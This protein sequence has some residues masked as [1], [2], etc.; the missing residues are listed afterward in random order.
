MTMRVSICG[1]LFCLPL[2]AA[3]GDIGA[4]EM[5]KSHPFTVNA[6][7]VKGCVLGSGASD[8]DTFGNLNFGQISSLDSDIRIVSRI[9][10]GSVQLRCNPELNVILALSIG[11]HVTGSIT[12]GRKLQNATSGET[13]LYQLYQD[14]NYSI[15][16]G[17][18]SNGGMVRTITATGNT[19]EINV[20]ARLFSSSILPT[21]GIYSDTVLL[22]IIY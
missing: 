7:V 9:G 1:L 8:T 6:S 13:L 3:L 18:G 10:A 15:L 19:Q 16:W 4:N 14:R 20:Y 21:S 12:A 17:D 22:T 5:T 2:C 11:N